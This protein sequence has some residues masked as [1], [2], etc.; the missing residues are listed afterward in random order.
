[1]ITVEAWTTIRYVHAQGK[2]QDPIARELGIARN[3][4]PRALFGRPHSVPASLRKNEPLGVERGP[5]TRACCQGLG[6]PSSTELRSR[7]DNPYGY[8]RRIR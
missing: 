7:T 4:V 5:Q 8:I 2:G 6:P 1:M 3:T